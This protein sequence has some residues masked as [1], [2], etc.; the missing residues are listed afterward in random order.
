VAVLQRGG[1]QTAL[2]LHGFVFSGVPLGIYNLRCSSRTPLQDDGIIPVVCALA[3]GP[4]LK[5]T[6]A[7]YTVF[8]F[9]G[10]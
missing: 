5:L 10:L 7:L 6:K 1:F 9:R 8:L 2:L 4:G 3:F